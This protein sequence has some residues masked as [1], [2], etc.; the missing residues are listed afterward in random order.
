MWVFS[1]SY[2]FLL[3]NVVAFIGFDLVE[4]AWIQD[5]IFTIN[6]LQVI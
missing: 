5:L 4:L 6:C 1:E 2:H 3:V